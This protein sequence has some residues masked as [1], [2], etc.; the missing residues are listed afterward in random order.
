M[1]EQ[2]QE[3]PLTRRE[4]RLRQQAAQQ[5]AEQRGDENAQVAAAGVEPTTPA[6]SD[7]EIEID[8]FNADGSPRTR[9]ELRELR[10]AALAEL[11]AER[12][13]KL[14][15]EGV[16]GPE[17]SEEAR[18][19]EEPE[20]PDTVDEPVEELTSRDDDEA[21]ADE[22]SSAVVPSEDETGDTADDEQFDDS[23]GAPTEA[24]SL[25]DLIEATEAPAQSGGTDAVAALFA[26]EETESPEDATDSE[27]PVEEPEAE[28]APEP[29]IEAEPDL[30]AAAEEDSDSD[31][32]SEEGDEVADEL[33]EDV[34]RVE[35]EDS[36]EG[37]SETADESQTGGYSFPDI[38][39]PEEWRSVF[40]DP[41]RGEQ[42]TSSDS[43]GDF[44]DL[45]SRAVAQ[46][47]STGRTGASALILP[48]H[49]GDTGGLAGPLGATGELFV[50]GSIDLPKSLGETGGHAAVQSPQVVDPYI[51]GDHPD[52]LASAS[53]SGSMP[54]SALDAV[55]ARRRPEI[56][57]VAEPAKEKSKAPLILAISGGA[58]IVVLAGAVIFAATQGFFG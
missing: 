10:E 13:S 35:T 58:L 48:S 18:E 23:Y 30:P 11:A 34:E 4:L 41:A 54:V 7:V 31:L 49:P 40:D 52:S 32:G 26:D 16:D 57:V 37:D 28:S 46:E 39:P 19:L 45:I 43:S 6:I 27:S 47:G 29:E 38:Q 36:S 42:I 5:A 8:P 55:S 50:T 20:T 22:S 53:D 9:R 2:D 33:A 15:E 51:S 17:E 25:E 1:S 14:A 21:P 12:A 24:F 3:R 44:D 56:P